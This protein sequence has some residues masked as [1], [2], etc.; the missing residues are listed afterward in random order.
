MARNWAAWGLSQTWYREKTWRTFDAP[1]RDAYVKTSWVDVFAGA[2]ANDLLT[3]LWT[4]RHADIATLPH[5][6]GDFERALASI[7]A[8]AV[9]MPASTD[10]YFPPEDSVIEVAHM[11]HAELAVI[12]SIWGHQAGGHANS[13][14]DA[15]IAGHIARLLG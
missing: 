4:W 8:R 13:A 12:D 1:S 15:F 3:L 11:P 7:T 2:D 10:T 5:F 14:D 6:G 9:V